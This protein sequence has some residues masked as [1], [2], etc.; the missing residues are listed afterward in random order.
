MENKTHIYTQLETH[1]NKTIE[2]KKDYFKEGC[3]NVKK[4]I[5]KGGFLK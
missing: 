1:I 5:E 4:E 3:K 2:L